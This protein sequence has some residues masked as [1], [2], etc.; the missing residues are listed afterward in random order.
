MGRW[1]VD[2]NGGYIAADKVVECVS[3]EYNDAVQIHDLI[4]LSYIAVPSWNCCTK[5]S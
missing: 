1:I 4:Y 5:L 3:D 2:L